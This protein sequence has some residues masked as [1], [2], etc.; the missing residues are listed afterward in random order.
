MLTLVKSR[1]LEQGASSF[2]G[3]K[4]K[5]VLWKISLKGHAWCLG[6]HTAGGKGRCS[7]ELIEPALKFLYQMKSLCH[8]LN[9][10]L[11]LGHIGLT[12]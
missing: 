5:S 12:K 7:C 6:V 3:T 10:H 11:P 1:G 4:R 2:A 8:T 9:F